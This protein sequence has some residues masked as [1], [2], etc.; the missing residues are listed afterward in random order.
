VVAG[1]AEATAETAA[2]TPAKTTPET[3]APQGEAP[4]KAPA[5]RRRRSRAKP[6]P[7]EEGKEAAPIEVEAQPEPAAPATPETPAKAPARRRRRSRAKP[8]PAEEVKEAAPIEVEAQPEPAAP[9]T[10]ETPAKAPARRRRRSRAKPKPAEEA[11]EAAP[12][13]VEA[14]P[15]P[16]APATPETPA[17]APAK[18][19]RR[20]R[21]KAA[22]PAEAKE[23]A[24]AEVEAP[25][26]AVPSARPRRRRGH[27]REEEDQREGVLAGGGG[28]AQAD[29]VVNV[30]PRETRVAILEGGR[31]AELL[32]EREKAVLGNIY[33][34]RVEN[35]VPALDAAFVDCGIERN[36]FIHVGDA[37]PY[38]PVKEG[39]PKL[40]RISEVLQKGQEIIVQVTKGPLESK[41]ARATA[42]LSLPGRFVVLTRDG[43]AGVGVSKKIEDETERHRLRDIAASVKPAGWGCIVRTRA[44]GAGRAE[45][46]AD[47]RFLTK[48]W[49]TIDEKAA[50]SKA[51]ATLYEDLSLVFEILRD[52]VDQ[53]VRKMV[54][55][56]RETHDRVLRLLDTM[57][58]TLM[59]RV[60]LYE[61]KK[62]V[63]VEYE[64]EQEIE[65]ALR[66]RV[67][68]PH[69][70]HLSIEETEA[71]TVI[72]VNSGRFTSPTSLEDTVLRTNLEAA[73][74]IGR[75]LRLRDIGGIIVIDFIDMDRPE[76]RD[77][78]AEAMRVALHNDRMRTRVMHITRLGLMEMT[79]KRTDLS[80]GHQLLEACPWCSGSGRVMEATTVATRIVSELRSRA[81][82]SKVGGFVVLADPQVALALIGPHG[83]LIEGLEKEEVGRPVLVRADPNRH[84]EHFEIVAGDVRK[85]EKEYGFLTP[86]DLVDIAPENVLSVPV[87]GMLAQVKGVILEVTE[88]ETIS[89]PVKVRIIKASRSYARGTAV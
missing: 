43:Q 49:G 14:Q 2:R 48:T 67:W 46:Q 16:A 31:L 11:K 42:R 84:R 60:E 56:D 69:G 83:E 86:G 53:R 4:A 24:G 18:R 72:D 36:V 38:D 9:A 87:E 68:L 58:P 59:E 61:G 64:V 75:Q 79:R 76:H 13:E 88:P 63:F 47:I 27:A 8:K 65:R 7:A 30:T 66:P 62:P 77:R 5:R 57:A 78:V 44:Q 10:P 52:V 6:K 39:S 22:E 85:L 17:K 73:D 55:D 50:K 26:E 74:E 51:P 19:R 89:A 70:G 45:L 21:A 35:V 40:P 82:E 15:E 41:G 54:I 28:G 37:V 32:I 81:A 3:A 34:G 25:A 33:K 29:I 20:S 1:G 12:I 71:L 80:L 23:A